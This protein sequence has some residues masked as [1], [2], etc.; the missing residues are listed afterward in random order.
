MVRMLL[1]GYLLVFAVYASATAPLPEAGAE[2]QSSL[3]EAVHEPV[4]SKDFVPAP[5]SK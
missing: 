4:K 3:L 1:R 5:S 2:S